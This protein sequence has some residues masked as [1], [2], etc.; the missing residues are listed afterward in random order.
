LAHL[1][2]NVNAALLPIHVALYVYI[3]VSFVANLH[4]LQLCSPQAFYSQNMF[5][6]TK[7]LQKREH[8]ADTSSNNFL[9]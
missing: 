9:N 2:Q 7:Y 4:T 3:L 5:T 1:S 8:G 6:L